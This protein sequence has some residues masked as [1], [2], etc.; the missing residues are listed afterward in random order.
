ME[1]ISINIKQGLSPKQEIFAIAKEL[2]KKYLPTNQ[3][4][5]GKGYE[6]ID[7]QTQITI[8]R[9]STEKVFI[10][11]D[12]PICQK[13]FLQKY[14]KSCFSNFGGVT[15]KKMLC[16]EG[17]REAFVSIAPDRIRLKNDFT[18]MFHRR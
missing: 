2:G 16:S 7:L 6:L 14:G 3:K 1:K 8:N 17:C 10:T 11:Q 13:T 5:I 18:Y 4:M 9:V 15:K 12:C